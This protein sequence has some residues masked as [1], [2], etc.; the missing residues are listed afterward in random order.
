MAYDW[1]DANNAE[2]PFA[3]VFSTLPDGTED[4]RI[5]DFYGDDGPERAEAYS[6]WLNATAPAT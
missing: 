3:C 4:R 1:H 6:A 5:A 2:P